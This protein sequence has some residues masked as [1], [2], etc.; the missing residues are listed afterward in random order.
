MVVNLPECPVFGGFCK[1]FNDE[2]CGIDS[3]AQA[4]KDQGLSTDCPHRS[5][6]EEEEV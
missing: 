2:Q 4:L 6:Y 1:L 3:N 5:E